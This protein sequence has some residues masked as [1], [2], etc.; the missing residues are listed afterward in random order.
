MGYDHGRHQETI[1]PTI[2]SKGEMFTHRR[3]HS[4][5]DRPAKRDALQSRAC[6]R[7]GLNHDRLPVTLCAEWIF[8]GRGEENVSERGE[9]TA[10]GKRTG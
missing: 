5:D 10:E 1:H 3:K 8:S 9:R 6:R 4:R 7:S 2:P